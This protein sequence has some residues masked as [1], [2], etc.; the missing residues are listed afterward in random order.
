MNLYSAYHQGYNKEAGD[1]F[2]KW[3][4]VGF[5]ILMTIFFLILFVFLQK[6]QAN[7]SACVHAER[8][9][10]INTNINPAPTNIA[11]KPNRYFFI[12]SSFKLNKFKQT[13]LN[14]ET[15][16]LFPGKVLTCKRFSLLV[17]VMMIGPLMVNQKPI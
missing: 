5:I 10:C 13:H 3:Y 9:P 6:W 14:R 17:Q 4:P 1:Y 2:V 11:P 15:M 7:P 8:S 16:T 12:G